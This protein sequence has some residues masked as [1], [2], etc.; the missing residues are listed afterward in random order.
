[1]LR[2]SFYYIRLTRHR[3]QAVAGVHR[4]WQH[5]RQ[6]ANSFRLD[7]CAHNQQAAWKSRERDGALGDDGERFD[8]RFA[9]KPLV[10]HGIRNVRVSS[11]ISPRRAPGV[12]CQ[13][14]MLLERFLRV[15][16]GTAA[17]CVICIQQNSI[18][19]Y[20]NNSLN[21]Q[22]IRFFFSSVSELSL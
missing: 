6:I 11:S 18:A 8:I 19:K 16:A 14:S 4:K 3:R 10:R 7:P 22:Y 15:K 13:T 17:T 12:Q 2:R 21:Q 9:F 20:I 1:M 5:Y